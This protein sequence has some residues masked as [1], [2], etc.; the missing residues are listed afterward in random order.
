M[1]GDVLE[2][3][4]SDIEKRL[5][6]LAERVA[7]AQRLEAALGALEDVAGPSTP[8]NAT[9]IA[10]SAPRGHKPRRASG[11]R[12][13]TSGG[14]EQLVLSALEGQSEALDIKTVAA[15]AG[16]KPA[17]ASHTLKKL[18]RHGRLTQGTAPGSRG[19]I[20]LVFSLATQVPAAPSENGASETPSAAPKA[21][22]YA[23]RKPGRKAKAA[24]KAA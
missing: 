1:P 7:E 21:K 17:T 3:A 23:R 6:A 15:R 19:K 8:R 4:R 11:R 9:S 24:A 16:L 10:P 2:Q 13:R 14:S 20:K 18:A 12:R 5:R 22:R